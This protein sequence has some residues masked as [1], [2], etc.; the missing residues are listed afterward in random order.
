M[1][2]LQGIIL[3]TNLGVII[4]IIEQAHPLKTTNAHRPTLQVIV[5]IE[6]AV[7]VCHLEEAA[8]CLVVA[9]EDL[10]V[11]AEDKRTKLIKIT[12]S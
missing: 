11:E 8:E 12:H 3:K 5:P 4:I 9:V 7:A 1:I 10:R 6:A 2:L